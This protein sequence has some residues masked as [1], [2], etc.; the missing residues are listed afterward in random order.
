[1]KRNY[2]T[3]LFLF[4]SL[5]V[6]S[7]TPADSLVKFTD[8]S[9]H[10][11]FEKQSFIHREQGNELNLCL[12]TDKNMT[13]DNAA[14]LKRNYSDMIQ[15]LRI[16]KITA[17]NF[18]QKFKNAHKIIFNKPSMQYYENAEFADIFKNGY[19][20][21]LTSTV[22]YSL[23]LKDLNIPSFFL[24]TLNKADIIINPDGEQVI[25]DAENRKDENGYFNSSGN[26]GYILNMLDKNIRI[27]SE[28]QYNSTKG[29]VA[30]RF[31]E[32]DILKKNQLA[33]TIYYY[34][35]LQQLNAQKS[36]EAY[37][38]IKKACY[39]YP[40]ETFIASMFTMLTARLEHCD[41]SKVEDVDLLGQ[42]FKFKFDNFDYIKNTFMN[43]M[44]VKI[45][46]QN[47]LPYCTAAYNRL[48]PQIT[49]E[50][51]ANEISYGYYI[52]SANCRSMDAD[53]KLRQTLQAL[54]LKPNDKAALYLV[55]VQLDVM[56]NITDDK[57]SLMDTL[58]FYA[59]EMM[60]TEAAG[61]IKNAQ[62]LN[63]LVL[64]ISD[65]S[66]NHLKEGIQFMTL[67]ESSFNLPLPSSEYRYK[68]ENAYYEYAMYYV[69][70]NNRAMAQKIVDKGLH[71]IPNSN[72]IQ[73]ATFNFHAQ[74]P[75]ISKLKLTKKEFEKYMKNNGPNR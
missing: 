74:K 32:S 41:F 20:N 45:L 62:L 19:F 47:D 71:Y 14:R 60:D 23:A 50:L 28:Y 21:Y 61:L 53:K 11:E 59:K 3:V 15:L 44:K 40:D 49:D 68:I 31:K 34:K 75:K 38:L 52:A 73:T 1:M 30:V 54:K 67:F 10:S 63:Y 25:L 37:S 4:M 36:D 56:G 16:E 42:L 7:N 12:A 17:K 51:L 72:M 29:N 22:L 48:L 27:G 64:A 35:A 57:K 65:F 2:S 46:Q 58:D 39:L 24:F 9:F 26:K 69:R 18:R 70:F 6:F 5:L 66:S 55:G 8:L 33:A 13:E 43:V